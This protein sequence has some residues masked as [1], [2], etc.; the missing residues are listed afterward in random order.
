MLV[1]AKMFIIFDLLVYSVY[2]T[3][4]A[5]THT[6]DVFLMIFGYTIFSGV[7]MNT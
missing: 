1:M 6:A 4:V 7:H 5:V 3:R 2:P